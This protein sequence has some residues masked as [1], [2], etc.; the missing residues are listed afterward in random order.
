[1][2]ER[3][4]VDRGPLSDERALSIRPPFAQEILDGEKVIEYRGR[5]T[6]FRGRVWLHE[7]GPQG[8]GIVGSMEIYE[9]RES[10]E[11]DGEW[12]WFLRNVVALKS[13]VACTGQ[14]GL[15]KVPVSVLAECGQAH[16]AVPSKPQPEPERPRK[17][18]VA[19]REPKRSQTDEDWDQWHRDRDAEMERQCRS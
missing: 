10:K 12:E 6:H 8:R 9:C 5:V 14:L 1:M 15:W 19:R 13:P 18:A 4:H 7:C 2:A 3:K 17:A 16:N 11:Y